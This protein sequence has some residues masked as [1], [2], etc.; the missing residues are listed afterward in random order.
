MFYIIF[1]SLEIHYSS[2]YGLKGID[3]T[4]F[5]VPPIAFANVSVNPSNLGFC[6]PESNC[7][8]AGLLNASSCRQGQI[9]TLTALIMERK[10]DKKL[11][12]RPF[13][14]YCQMKIN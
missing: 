14:P 3:L 10:F 11:T 9:F 1:R 7:L 12:K 8:P 4:R 5:V 6:T 13:V 2:S